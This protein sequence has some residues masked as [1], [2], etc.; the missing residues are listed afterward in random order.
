LICTFF[1]LIGV[2]EVVVQLYILFKIFMV[3]RLV[4]EA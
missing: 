2:E 4:F 3:I 1:T